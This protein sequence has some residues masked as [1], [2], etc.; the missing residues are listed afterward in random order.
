M[1]VYETLHTLF[2]SSCSDAVD[3]SP[4][5]EFSTSMFSNNPSFFRLL[6]LRTAIFS[7]NVSDQHY[8]SKGSL[9]INSQIKNA[10]IKF[11]VAFWDRFTTVSIFSISYLLALFVKLST[12]YKFVCNKWKVNYN[13][14]VSRT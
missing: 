11:N 6:S 4:S 3:Q 1:M 10:G 12:V 7:C 2:V 9:N 8:R 14:I 5:T 13:N